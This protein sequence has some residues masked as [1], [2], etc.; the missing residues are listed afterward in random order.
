MTTV[1]NDYNNRNHG[2]R[3]LFGPSAVYVHQVRV[4]C[5]PSTLTMS[6][7]ILEMNPVQ[8]HVSNMHQFEQQHSTSEVPA[9]ADHV[10]Q[11]VDKLLCFLLISPDFTN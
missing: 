4:V 6:S 9:T 5:F 2:G 10:Y 3:S 8:R 11:S 1:L 7:F